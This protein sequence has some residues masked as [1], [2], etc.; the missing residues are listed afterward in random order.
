MDIEIM[1]ITYRHV[2]NR[3]KELRLAKGLATQKALADL[4]G[5]TPVQIGRLENEERE[6]TRSWMERIAKAL[7]V[8]PADLISERAPRQ[9]TVP[10]VGYVGAGAMYYPDPV[11]GPWVGFDEVEAPPGVDDVV[12]VKA[13]GDSMS[14]VYRDGDLL[15]F[16]RNGQLVHEFVGRDCVVQV[17]N[18]PVY[19]K[20][21][22]RSRV[23]GLYTLRSYNSADVE[24]VD[25]EWAAPILWIRRG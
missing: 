1:E 15:Y 22:A 10:L 4:V 9:K 23:D 16:R 18:G 7:E 19:V 17:R 12:A 14:P 25:I 8:E 20:T 13:R 24:N 5:T 2:A 3:I 21:L 6:L 11:A